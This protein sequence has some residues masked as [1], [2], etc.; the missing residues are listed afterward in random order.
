MGDHN[1]VKK[2]IPT[3][4][5]IEKAFEHLINYCDYNSANQP[6]CCA[7]CEFVGIG[8]ALCHLLSKVRHDNKG[9]LITK[10]SE[11]IAKDIK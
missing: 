10:L 2:Q 6:K 8:P 3:S 11:I 5:K 1:S 7:N 4:K 9:L